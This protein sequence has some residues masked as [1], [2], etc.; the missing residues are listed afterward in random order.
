MER[1]F[2]AAIQR[3]VITSS[4]PCWKLAG[5]NNIKLVISSD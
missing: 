3:R 2:D 4:S 5:G 1:E